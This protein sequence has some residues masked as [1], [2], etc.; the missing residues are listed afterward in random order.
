[1]NNQM[2]FAIL[3]VL[4]KYFSAKGVAVSL[5]ECHRLS[6]FVVT[7]S[8]GQTVEILQSAMLSACK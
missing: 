5:P 3:A 4:L 8:K 2:E 1:M 6:V 7:H